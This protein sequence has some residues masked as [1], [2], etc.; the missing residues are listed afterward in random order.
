VSPPR[1]SVLLAVFNGE[2]HVAEAVES[3]LGQTLADLELIVVDDGS[4]DATPGIL[5]RYDDPRLVVARNPENLGLT[6]SLNRAL[7]LARGEYVARQDADDRSFPERLERQVSFLEA[8]TGVAACGTWAGLWANGRFVRT[9]CPPGQPHEIARVLPTA[10]QFVHGTLVFRRSAL[11]ALGGYREQFRY[12]Q[13]YDLLL[14]AGERFPLANVEEELY[15]LRLHAESL[16]LRR[17]ERQQVYA[18]LARDL[19]AERAGGGSDALERGEPIDALLDAVAHREGRSRFYSYLAE[20]ALLLGDVRA[21]RRA[22]LG[23][24]RCYPHSPRLY[25]LLLR[26]F[27]RRG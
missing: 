2:A 18:Q 6:R 17:L 9:V 8:E 3:I 14:R 22:L 20:S 12:A 4:T 21:H 11:E 16:S 27:A 26:S 15:E 13:D 10:N 19:A 1:V 23:L 25:F 5:A 7:E 24:I